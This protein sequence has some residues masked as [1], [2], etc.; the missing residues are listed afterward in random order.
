[1]RILYG[2]LL[3]CGMNLNS[4]GV[5]I[6]ETFKRLYNARGEAER[7][8]PPLECLKNPHPLPNDREGGQHG[9]QWRGFH[10][11]CRAASAVYMVSNIYMWDELK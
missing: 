1:M 6:F 7:I 8:I 9:L 4:A 3:A 10:M 2:Y 5:W 11:I